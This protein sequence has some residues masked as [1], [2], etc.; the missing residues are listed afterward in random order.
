MIVKDKNKTKKKYVEIICK[1]NEV[2]KLKQKK[3]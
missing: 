3:N 1:L 2:H